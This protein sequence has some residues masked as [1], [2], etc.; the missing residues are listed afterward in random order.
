MPTNMRQPW[1]MAIL[2][3]GLSFLIQAQPALSFGDA[4][5]ADQKEK[6]A[7][8]EPSPVDLLTAV[9]QGEISVDAE[10]SGDGRM[11]LSLTNKT[12][13]KLRVVLPPGLIASGATGQFGGMG[14]M[15]GGMGGMGGGM[16]GGMGGGMGGMGGGGGGGRGGRGGRGGMGRGGEGSGGTG[17][18][19]DGGVE[20]GVSNM[21]S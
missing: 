17:G 9:R 19:V 3:G 7:S 5:S 2:A 14:G 21:R 12:K 20:G 18:G 6:V 10:G 16:M 11:T 8:E 4:P 13:R 15:G 1:R